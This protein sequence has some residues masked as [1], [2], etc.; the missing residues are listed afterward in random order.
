MLGIRFSFCVLSF[1]KKKIS[2]HTRQQQPQRS[3]RKKVGT[4]VR[5]SISFFPFPPS[6]PYSTPHRHF[7]EL[8]AFREMLDTLEPA[9]RLLAR[10]PVLQFDRIQNV[11]AS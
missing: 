11:P 3:P 5:P 1:A 7:N 2:A 4:P 9:D 6:P 8:K 10:P